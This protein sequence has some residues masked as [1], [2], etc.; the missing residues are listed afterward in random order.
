MGLEVAL[1]SMLHVN[2]INAFSFQKNYNYHGKLSS[3]SRDSMR[4][5]LLH[6]SAN[7]ESSSSSSTPPPAEEVDTPSPSAESQEETTIE[8]NTTEE[9]DEEEEEETKEDPE[10]TALKEEISSL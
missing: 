8:E 2:D 7:E 10:L 5:V 3:V 4:A 6:M 1:L 9:E